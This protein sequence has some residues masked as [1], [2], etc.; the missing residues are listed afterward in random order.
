MTTTSLLVAEH[1]KKRHDHV[2]RAIRAIMAASPEEVWRP[3]FGARDYV[4]RRGKTQPIIDLTHDGFAVAVM[5]FT[6]AASAC[7]ERSA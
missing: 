7:G 5:G 1:F 4:D 2:L 6:G 3:N